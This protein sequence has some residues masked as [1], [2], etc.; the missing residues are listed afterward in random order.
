MRD[1]YHEELQNL[2]ESMLKMG[3]MVE[4]VIDIALKS[5]I[6]QDLEKAQEVIELDDKIDI[7]EIEIEKKCLELIALQQPV[8]KDLRKISTILKIITDMERIGDHGVNIAR[9]TQKIGKQP[10]IKPLIDIPKMSDLA[11]TMVKKSLD[12][13]IME[14]IE[15]AKQVAEMDDLVDDT[16]EDI[17]TELLGML[18]EDENIMNQVVNLLFIGRFIE[19]IGDH[20]TNI[21]ERIIYMIDGKRVKF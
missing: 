20:T 10:L 21:C 9:V 12:S 16:Y 2:Q 14:D 8:G 1:S 4:N 5:L 7:L 17:Y 11:K 6:E 3:A 15:L 13:Y 19:R 18:R